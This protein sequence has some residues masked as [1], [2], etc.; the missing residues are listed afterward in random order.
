MPDHLVDLASGQR[1]A[2]SG[3]DSNRRFGRSAEITAT[4]L[5]LASLEAAFIVGTEIVADGGMSEL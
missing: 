3:A 4:A 1:C 2:H 5:H